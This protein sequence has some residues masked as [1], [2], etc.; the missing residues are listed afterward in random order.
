MD[1]RNFIK[2]GALSVASLSLFNQSFAFSPDGFKRNPN[3]KPISGSWFEFAHGS[4][5]EG[6]YWNPALPHFTTEQWKAKVLEI[7]ETG[8]EYLVLMSVANNGKTYYPSA[9]QPRYEYACPD[10]LEAIL[11]AADECGV[12]FFVSNDFWADWAETSKMMTDPEIARLREKGMEEIAGKYAHHKSFYGWYYPNESGFWNTIDETTIKYVNECNRVAKKLTPGRVNLIAPYGTK[13]V[14]FDDSYVRQLDKL[15]IDIVAYQDEI[16]VKKTRVGT[17]G[18]Y[19][20][21]L[22]K[23][24]QK[25]GRSRLWA[26]M[27]I[28]EFE[29]EVYNSALVPAEFDRILK[30]MEDISPFVEHIL[31]YQY[32]G[33]MNKPGSL[34]SAGHSNSEKL[35]TDYMTWLKAQQ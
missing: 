25:A 17:A 12:K 33:I 14:R 32:L 35:Y 15:D 18:K 29:G 21:T 31:I 8:M 6:K 7:S 16:G 11:S 10:P 13:S 20:E 9:I 4:D 27:E 2:S 30:Q 26:D 22:Y 1:R 5:V 3:I 28:F 24:H 23:S 34:A 19:Y